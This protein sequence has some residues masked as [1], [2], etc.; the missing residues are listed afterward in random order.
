MVKK[1]SDGSSHTVSDLFQDL[2]IT[3]QGA[4]K[5]LQV[6]ADADVVTL[7]P[8]GRNTEVRLEPSSLAS[9]KSFI[10]GLELQWD[11]RLT[12]LQ[13]FVENSHS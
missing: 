10:A 4:R 3:R 6:L 7:Q 1:L 13:D 8:K 2:E 11:N 5:H 12:A 9:L